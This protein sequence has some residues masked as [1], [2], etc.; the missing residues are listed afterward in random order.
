MPIIKSAIKRAKQTNVK[1]ER[2]K[3]FRTRMLTLYKN[4]KKLVA[5]WEKEKAAN[6]I[7]EAFSSIDV[8]SK[9]NIIHKNNAARKKSELAKIVWSTPTSKK[10]E[11]KTT[12]KKTA[13]KPESKATAKTSAK[14]TSAKPAT[15]KSTTEKEI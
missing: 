8:A 9:K 14:K 6:F 12:A 11:T 1:T 7:S 4:I 15:K 3:H 2:N 13:A 5:W 10:K